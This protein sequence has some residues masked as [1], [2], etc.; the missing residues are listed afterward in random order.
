M[1]T[2]PNFLPDYRKWNTNILE[3][4]CKSQGRVKSTSQKIKNMDFI[5]KIIILEEKWNEKKKVS[6]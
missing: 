6:K 4:S 2:I 5:F 1:H 3:G